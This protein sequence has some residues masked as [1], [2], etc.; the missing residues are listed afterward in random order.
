LVG[1]SSLR[2]VGGNILLGV[3]YPD[4]ADANYV[5]DLTRRFLE[6]TDATGTYGKSRLQVCA[7][8]R[9][10]FMREAAVGEMNY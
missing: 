10:G 9:I 8:L 6:V 3:G 2:V 4:S 7:A 1:T 5:H